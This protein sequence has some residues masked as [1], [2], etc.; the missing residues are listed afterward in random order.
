M[1]W[2]RFRPGAIHVCWLS[3]LLVLDLAERVFLR[4]LRLSF[5]HKNQQ[6]K[7]QFDQN[8]GTRWKPADFLSNVV[9]L[10]SCSLAELHL[11]WILQFPAQPTFKTPIWKRTMW[12]ST[13]SPV[14]SSLFSR[15]LQSSSQTPLGWHWESLETN[16]YFSVQPS[17]CAWQICYYFSSLEA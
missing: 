17:C 5:L 11:S 13:T 8:R 4:V 12:Y 6:S 2:V 10:L 14:T 9:I 16:A 15:D 1:A 7:F 3:L